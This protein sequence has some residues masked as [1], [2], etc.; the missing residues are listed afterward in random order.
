MKK[1]LQLFRVVLCSFCVDAT[2]QK[3]DVDSTYIAPTSWRVVKDYVIS[4]TVQTQLCV[5]HPLTASV[6]KYP[7][8]L[9]SMCVH[10]LDINH[11]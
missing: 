6:R 11:D 10:M 3:W 9:Y 8:L 1:E 2:H 7:T 5:R 4:L